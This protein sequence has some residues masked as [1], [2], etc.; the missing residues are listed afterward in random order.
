MNPPDVDD[1]PDAPDAP[2][3]TDASDATDAQDTPGASDPDDVAPDQDDGSRAPE[4]DDGVL[5]AIEEHVRSDLD[6][7]V[8]GFLVGTLGDGTAHVTASV[9]ALRAQTGTTNVTFT[10]D[11]W[12]DVLATVDDDHPGEAIVG[13]YHS[14][15]GFGVFLSD[16]DKFIHANFFPDPVMVALVVDPLSGDAGWFAG[17]TDPRPTGSYTIE[18]ST[19]PAEKAAEDV[20]SRSRASTLGMVAA[21]A[22]VVAFALGW[23]LAPDGDGDDSAGAGG[24]GADGALVEAQARAEAAEAYAAEL[25]AALVEAVESGEA[26]VSDSSGQVTYTVA[27]GDSLSGIARRFYGDGA[28]WPQIA[29]ANGID[30]DLIA[31]GATLVLPGLFE[32]GGPGSLQLDEPQETTDG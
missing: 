32:G 6:K 14:H 11:V 7:E 25:E 2:G 27:A 23:L 22:V 15:P 12:E 29:E 26:S 4:V 24:P 9:P 17:G 31:P 16:H 19:P 20:E 18:P 8:G 30:G 1:A 3:A 21:A 28:R 13:W 5:D 10:H